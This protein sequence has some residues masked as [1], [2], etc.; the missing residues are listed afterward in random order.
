MNGRNILDANQKSIYTTEYTYSR[1][2]SSK[3][4]LEEHSAGHTYGSPGIL[5]NQGQH[6]DPCPLVPET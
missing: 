3:I 6:F 5:G 1:P 2:D 4:T